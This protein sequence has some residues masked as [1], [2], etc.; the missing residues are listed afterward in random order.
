[1][2]GKLIP[3]INQALKAGKI[4]VVDCRKVDKYLRGMHCQSTGLAL[5][6]PVAQILEAV[7]LGCILA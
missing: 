5:P 4:D 3:N 2:A 6:F 1:M 7:Q